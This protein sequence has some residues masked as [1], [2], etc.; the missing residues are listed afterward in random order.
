MSMIDPRYFAFVVPDE[1]FKPF[2]ES[3]S[4]DRRLHDALAD[5][6]EGIEFWKTLA[7][8]SQANR[9]RSA[10]VSKSQRLSP[11]SLH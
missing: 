9:R 5:V 6:E 2:R 3:F 1:M 11:R 4:V 8:S 7:G 10:P